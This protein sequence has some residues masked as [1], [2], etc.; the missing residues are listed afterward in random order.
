MFLAKPTFTCSSRQRLRPTLV[1]NGSS[2]ALPHMQSNMYTIYD[3]GGNCDKWLS[4]VLYDQIRLINIRWSTHGNFLKSMHL[5]I[6]DCSWPL[7][8]CLKLHKPSHYSKILDILK[9]GYFILGH[10]RIAMF[11]YP[12]DKIFINYGWYIVFIGPFSKICQ[13]EVPSPVFVTQ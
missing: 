5:L 7:A 9:M 4:A 13:T 8:I 11:Y 12:I 2:G 10:N 3:S 6:L 1:T